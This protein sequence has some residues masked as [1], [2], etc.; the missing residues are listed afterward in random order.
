MSSSPIRLVNSQWIYGWWWLGGHWRCICCACVVFMDMW[1]IPSTISRSKG[2]CVEW[3]RTNASGSMVVN[4]KFHLLTSTITFRKLVGVHWV[5]DSMCSLLALVAFVNSMTTFCL[6]LSKDNLIKIPWGEWGASWGV[7]K[8]DLM[9]LRRN[10][11]PLGPTME[12]RNF[13]RRYIFL[14]R[15]LFWTPCSVGTSTLG[16]TIGGDRCLEFQNIIVITTLP[17]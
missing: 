1:S 12:S 6:L 9:A 13:V 7:E 11:L 14:F 16:T 15:C 4:L 10:E 17:P 5:V 8:V 2:G 3:I